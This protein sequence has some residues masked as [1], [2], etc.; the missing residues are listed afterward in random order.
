LRA[1][2]RG[3]G[4]R[5]GEPRPVEVS[6]L[7]SLSLYLVVVDRIGGLQATE[8]KG[9]LSLSA[10]STV[11]TEA[12]AQGEEWKAA[13]GCTHTAQHGLPSL[14]RPPPSPLTHARTHT[15]TH[16]HTHTH[17]HT[18]T[19]MHHPPHSHETVV[20]TMGSLPLNR[21]RGYLGVRRTWVKTVST[22][23]CPPPSLGPVLGSRNRRTRRTTET[24]DP[25]SAL[26]P[27]TWV[28]DD[29]SSTEPNPATAAAPPPLAHA[30]YY[31]FDD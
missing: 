4:V 15:H 18:H 30:F 7:S 11:S 9:G 1:H 2:S 17:T 10:S 20:E 26:D 21:S 25:S 24:L 14:P 5:V 23:E 27:R 8:W 16:S 6:E 28:P 22:G 19:H 31:V 29:I 13:G 3:G 12:G